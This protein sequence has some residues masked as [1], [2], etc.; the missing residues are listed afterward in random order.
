MG[1]DLRMEPY[2]KKFEEDRP[3]LRILDEFC[4]SEI[5]ELFGH[6]GLK[7]D[8]FCAVA[9]KEGRLPHDAALRLLAAVEWHQVP[10]ESKGD[11][12]SA[13]IDKRNKLL[14]LLHYYRDWYEHPD[15]VPT[16]M[17]QFVGSAPDMAGRIGHL[18]EFE[19]QPWLVLR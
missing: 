10:P 16:Q 14:V 13:L 2:A 11:A 6:L 8:D 15:R 17:Q 9:D 1:V 7:W 18:P 12:R 3:G 5:D 4:F 19:R